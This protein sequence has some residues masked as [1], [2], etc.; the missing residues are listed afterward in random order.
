MNKQSILVAAICASL[1]ACATHGAVQDTGNSA[2]Q[3]EAKASASTP[4]A[5]VQT[6]VTMDAAAVIEARRAAYVLSAATFGGLKGSIDRAETGPERMLATIALVRWARALPGMFP[7][8]TNVGK[9]RALPTVWSDRATFNAKAKEYADAALRL[10]QLVQAGD[11]AALAEQWTVTQKICSSCHEQFRQP[12][13]TPP[14][15]APK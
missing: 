8:G 14:P 13:P 15:T 12:D 2:P 10:N 3:G 4:T 6:D 9:T 5:T 1:L 7:E 11:N